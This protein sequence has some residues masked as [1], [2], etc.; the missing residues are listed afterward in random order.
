VE[1][2]FNST[3]WRTVLETVRDTKIGDRG[4]RS[5][6]IGFISQ[7]FSER[8]PVSKVWRPDLF[9]NTLLF[10]PLLCQMTAIALAL[11]LISASIPG[12]SP[13]AQWIFSLCSSQIHQNNRLEAATMLFTDNLTHSLVC[14]VDA[15]N[16]HLPDRNWLFSISRL[17]VEFDPDNFSYPAKIVRVAGKYI[18]F[19]I[20]RNSLLFL[21]L[22]FSID[23][24]WFSTQ[25]NRRYV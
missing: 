19:P 22:L 7:G 12:G 6:S 9:E 15:L 2:P 18:S 5:K 23:S 8:D 21:P 14:H 11:G 1:E 4:P 20:L 16:G 17:A 25:T 13:L 24:H 10:A 3:D